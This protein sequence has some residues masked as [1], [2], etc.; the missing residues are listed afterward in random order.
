M[1]NDLDF[2]RLADEVASRLIDQSGPRVSFAQLA[3]DWQPGEIHEQGAVVSHQG[4]IWQARVR[5]AARPTA[6]TGEWLLLT[7]GIRLIRSYQERE[8]PRVFGLMVGLTSGR[9]IDLPFRLALP[10]HRGQYRAG[11]HYFEGDEVE[12]GGATFRALIE[13]PGTPDGEGWIVVAARGRQGI[14]GERGPEGKT[15]PP[16]EHGECGPEGPPGARGEAGEPG[17]RAPGIIGVEPVP[18]QPGCIRVVLDDG[19]ISDPVYVA[20]M[21]FVGLYRPGAEYERGDIVRLGFN[22][23]ICVE[24]TGDVP[25]AN[26]SKWTI[27]LV[28]PEMGL[29]GDGSGGPAPPIDLPA[30]DL[31]YLL[32]SGD[33]ITGPLRFD[34]AA[35]PDAP[36]HPGIIFS[37]RGGQM[38]WSM[39]GLIIQRGG[40]GGE[41]IFTENSDGTNR[42]AVLDAATG[43]RKVGD[44]MTGPLTLPP[45]AGNA[46][47]LAFDGADV[48]FWRPAGQSLALEFNS[49]NVMAW[50]VGLI[51]AL[52]T[53]DMTD[54]QIANLADP[55]LAT[56]AVNKR[57]VDNA[58]G[59]VG[60]FL[61]LAGGTMA[62][63]ILFEPAQGLGFEPGLSAIF[64]TGGLRLRRD[65]TNTP[66][67]IEDYDGSGRSA[68]I[69]ALLGDA[70]YMQQAEADARYLQLAGGQMTGPLLSTM[71][72]GNS[73]ALMIGTNDTGFYRIG[74]TLF[75]TV[76]FQT[77][78]TWT[79]NEVLPG[80][81][82]NM[83]GR[84]ISNVLNG[85]AS[86]AVNRQYVDDAIAASVA[87]AALRTY[88]Y[89]PNEVTIA[90]AAA[91]FFDVTIPV[92]AGPPRNI[93]V[94][95]DPVFASNDPQ[96]PWQ[97][98]YGTSLSSIECPVTAY[99][100]GAEPTSIFRSGAKFT[101]A[102]ST[103]TGSI[104]VAITA[105]TTSTG[106]MPLIQVGIGGTIAPSMRSIVTV[107]DL[108]TV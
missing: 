14:T 53:F 23:W 68:I 79:G 18:E 106:V 16:G 37:L 32:K 81:T 102:V 75:L 97:V 28:A 107:Q 44:R 34:P 8:D 17:P 3:R 82:I 25:I 64:E 61:P 50:T 7:N 31:R 20:T 73:P 13:A 46:P 99:K 84:S 35:G 104:R 83:Q 65:I 108:G 85:A 74:S 98:L 71:G 21:R 30:L 9:T 70:R 62:G 55:T 93:L 15:G 40:Q 101:A 33:N 59:T 100:F 56:D 67:T 27:F 77:A 19:S 63:V 5:T 86:S 26:S 1:P 57:Y 96:G 45:G 94:S 2:T 69:T 95:V 80:A 4:G 49:I 47:A 43:V 12:F 89:M 39:Q 76:G 103:A 105:R 24:S 54:N 36:N 92:P 78:M 87:P 91:T 52:T 22:L 10:V 58:V 90:A 66:P 38:Y 41:D 48:G 51:Q 72:A 42:Q 88:A 11:A 29:G 60:G 6:E